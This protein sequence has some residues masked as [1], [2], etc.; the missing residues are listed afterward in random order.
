MSFRSGPGHLG[1]NA[2]SIQ[3]ALRRCM[4]QAPVPFAITRGAAHT[5]VYANSAFCRLAGL[6]N[7][8]AIGAPIA[9]AFT[10]TQGRA[11]RELLDRALRDGLE[12][13][14]HGIDVMSESASAWQCSVWPVIAANGRAEALGIEIR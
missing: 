9:N 3:E 1:A 11:L 12:L 4:Q 7:S 5:L 8:D 14:D 13:V 2:T 6:P 10:A